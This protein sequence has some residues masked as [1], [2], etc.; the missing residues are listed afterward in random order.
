[1]YSGIVKPVRRSSIAAAVHSC[2]ETVYSV[3]VPSRTVVGD[4][5]AAKHFSEYAE[6]ECVVERR[7]RVA[8]IDRR[9][10]VVRSGP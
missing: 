2:R 6:R 7:C 9:T 3:I 5:R 8:A 4:V 1:M 10:S